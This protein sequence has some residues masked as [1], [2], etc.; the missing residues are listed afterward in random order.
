[1]KKNCQYDY[2]YK[3][4]IGNQTKD[5]SSF[6]LI[7]LFH[8]QRKHDPELKPPK[9]NKT[10]PE[11]PIFCK[12]QTEKATQLP[13]SSIAKEGRAFI[14]DHQ[15]IINQRTAPMHSLVVLIMYA[16]KDFTIPT[17]Q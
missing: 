2:W 8:S 13:T 6:I 5:L 17:S 1:M 16:Y 15:K 11:L 4:L 3:K 14:K 12:Q 7:Y 10:I 9:R